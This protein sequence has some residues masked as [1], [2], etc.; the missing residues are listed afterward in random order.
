MREELTEDDQ[1][2]AYRVTWFAPERPVG[3]TAFV[4]AD[5]AAETGTDSEAQ[6]FPKE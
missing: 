6:G 1:R 2:S 4:R 5:D 3:G